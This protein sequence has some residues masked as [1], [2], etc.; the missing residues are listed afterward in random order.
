MCPQVMQ[1]HSLVE[2]STSKTLLHTQDF[3]L[4]YCVGRQS[5]A[6]AERQE[7]P[8]TSLER[9]LQKFLPLQSGHQV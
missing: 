6:R 4:A 7:I 9:R 5:G 8:N 1:R 3:T 2:M